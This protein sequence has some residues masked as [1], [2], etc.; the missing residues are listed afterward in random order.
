MFGMVAATG[1][2]ILADVDFK[3]NRNNLYIVAIV[4][5]LR[6]DPAG[7]AALDAAD[8]ARPAPAA[9]IAASC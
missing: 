8:G 5:R 7:G 9:R 4:D 1:I 2:R 6:H 3:N